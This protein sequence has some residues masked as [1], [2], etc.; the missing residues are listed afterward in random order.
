[1]NPHSCFKSLC[2]HRLHTAVGRVLIIPVKANQI[3]HWQTS[4]KRAKET[5]RTMGR[6]FL[7]KEGPLYRVHGQGCMPLVCGD[8]DDGSLE[9]RQ[10]WPW[11]GCCGNQSKYKIHKSE[12]VQCAGSAGGHSGLCVE[13]RIHGVVLRDPNRFKG[14]SKEE[15]WPRGLGI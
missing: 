7:A 5:Q 15:T 6:K 11:G 12:R 14:E 4:V 9:M 8:L 2:S 1:M 10:S 3:R 13:K